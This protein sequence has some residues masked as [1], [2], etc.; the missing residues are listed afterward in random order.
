M[1]SR[2]MLINVAFAILGVF[3]F[4][5]LAKLLLFCAGLGFEVGQQTKTVRWFV[6]LRDRYLQKLTCPFLCFSE[7]QQ[8]ATRLASINCQSIKSYKMPLTNS[9][10]ELND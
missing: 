10:N 7:L 9:Y 1:V 6:V 4:F 8:E 2:N 3:I 5:L